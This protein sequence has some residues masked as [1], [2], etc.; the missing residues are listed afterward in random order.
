MKLRVTIDI[1]SGVPNPVVE[2]DGPE[3]SAVLEWLSRDESYP[4]VP[5]ASS[6]QRLAIAGSLLNRSESAH[7]G[8]RE[9]FA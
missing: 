9:G 5:R 8:S 2:I 3:A 6:A 7:V 1:F 4:S